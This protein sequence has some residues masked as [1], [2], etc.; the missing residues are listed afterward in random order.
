MP[1]RRITIGNAADWTQMG[2]NNEA[3]PRDETT[4][5]CLICGTRLSIYNLRQYCFA[6]R[7]RGRLQEI[8][9][10]EQVADSKRQEKRDKDNKRKRLKCLKKH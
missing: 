1:Q 10:E 9:L 7:I 5:Y 3:P 6:H 2:R 4:R 8:K